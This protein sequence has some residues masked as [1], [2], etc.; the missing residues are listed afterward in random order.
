MP[1]ILNIMIVLALVLWAFGSSS[2]QQPLDRPRNVVLIGWDGAQRNHVNECLEREELPNLKQLISE[3]IMVEIDIKGTTD[4]KAGWTQILTGYDPEITGVYSN[5]RYQPIPKGYTN[6]ARLKQFFGPAFVAVAVIGKKGHVDADPPARIQ[7]DPKRASEIQALRRAQR[8]R[9]AARAERQLLREGKYI[10]GKIVEKGDTMYVD[11]PGKPYYNSKDGMDLFLNG[12]MENA[13]VGE[14]TLEL[15][16]KYRD[17]R[18]FLFVHFAEVDHNGHRFG[19]N[20]KEYN[21]ALISCDTFTGKIVQ[22]LKGLGLYDG[23]LTYITADHGFDEGMTTHRSAP[24]VFLAT[25]DA[26]VR[27]NGSRA[28]ITPTILAR[29]GVDLSKIDPPLSGKPLIK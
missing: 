12:L 29:L 2:P 11:I 21:D 15:L 22:K 16:E 18:F 28:D 24:Y 27:R 1:R 26:H 9:R 25:N 7:L 10:G 4:T 5:A 19:E 17:K 20:S 23:T 13:K 14:K 8:P 6:G 3:G